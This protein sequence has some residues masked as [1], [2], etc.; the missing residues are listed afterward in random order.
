[1][2]PLRWLATTTAATGLGTTVGTA[3]ASATTAAATDSLP[4]FIQPIHIGGE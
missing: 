1:M 2:G 4:Q 3:M